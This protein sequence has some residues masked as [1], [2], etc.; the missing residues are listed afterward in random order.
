M[1]RNNVLLSICIP[2]YNR[3]DHIRRQLDFFKQEGAF[4]NEEIQFIVSDNHSTDGTGEW[5]KEYAS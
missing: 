3:L 5:L 2:T 4:S 1:D